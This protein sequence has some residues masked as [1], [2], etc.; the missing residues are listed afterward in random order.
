MG[1]LQLLVSIL[2]IGVLLWAANHLLTGYCQPWVLDLA[3]R[4]AVVGV[5]L[6][7]VFWALALLGIDLPV[8][9]R[10]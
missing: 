7:I 3:N 5:V 4:L 9:L 1:L 10:W 2:M 6:L 8:Q